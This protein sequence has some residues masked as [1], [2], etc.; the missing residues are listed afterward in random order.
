M[1]EEGFFVVV[2]DC[3]YV[4]GGLCGGVGYCVVVDVD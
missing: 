1:G 3:V 2:E 4:C